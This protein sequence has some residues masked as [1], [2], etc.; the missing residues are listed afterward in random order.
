M[1]NTASIRN[2]ALPNIDNQDYI[3]LGR[4]VKNIKM[5]EKDPQE[6]DMVKTLYSKLNNFVLELLTDSSL[7]M[8]SYDNSGMPKQLNNKTRTTGM[9]TENRNSL[10]TKTDTDKVE[11]RGKRQR[12]KPYNSVWSLYH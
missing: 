9:F 10:I 4:I 12:F 2:F 11:K 5:R 1:I 3:E 6:E 7:D 8:S